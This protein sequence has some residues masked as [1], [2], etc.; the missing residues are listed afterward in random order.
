L[1]SK[2]AKSPRTDKRNKESKLNFPKSPRGN[3]KKKKNN[4]SNDYDEE[5]YEI[6]L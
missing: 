3:D 6:A 4:R 5:E 2:H 1:S